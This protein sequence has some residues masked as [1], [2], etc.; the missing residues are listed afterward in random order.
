MLYASLL[1]L[2]RAD[3]HD[4]RQTS[5]TPFSGG[6]AGLSN[7][8]LAFQTNSYPAVRR[9]NPTSAAEHGFTSDTDLEYV[10]MIRTQ[11]FDNSFD[12]YTHGVS[13]ATEGQ[14]GKR[15]HV[16]VADVLSFDVAITNQADG[17]FGVILVETEI[18]PVT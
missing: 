13:N 3:V 2:G 16:E 17:A 14:L 7:C 5:H 8:G 4:K 18:R 6:A 11:P 9:T 1:L 15:D 10:K 12:V